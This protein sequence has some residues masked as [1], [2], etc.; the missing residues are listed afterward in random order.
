[1]NWRLFQSIL[2]SRGRGLLRLRRAHDRIG[3]ECLGSACARCCGVMG[4]GIVL[5]QGEAELL[6]LP[7]HSVGTTQTLEAKTCVCP[8]LRA[9][10]CSAYSSRPRGCRE[11]PWYN[12]GGELYYDAG[13]P[14]MSDQI[15][16][17][18]EVQT[19]S[20]VDSYFPNLP[21][22]IRGGMLALLKFW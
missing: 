8:L 15:D 3:F 7:T 12:I 17:R 5:T 6:Q 18:P 10:L 21:P 22:W 11:Y 2:R 13:C 1:M 16:T 20:P 9:G 4:Q 14:G 19:L